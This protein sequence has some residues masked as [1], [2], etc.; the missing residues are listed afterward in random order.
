MARDVD[1]RVWRAL[2]QVPWQELF[3]YRSF[4]LWLSG[5]G[6]IH[7]LPT[8]APQLSTALRTAIES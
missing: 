8:S 6:P 2:S 3:G 1:P 7:A 5:A 4:L